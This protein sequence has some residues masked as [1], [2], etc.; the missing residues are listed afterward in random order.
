MLEGKFEKKF[1]RLDLLI[2]NAGINSKDDPNEL[3]DRKSRYLPADLDPEEIIRHI[4]I[5]SISILMVKHF[6]VLEK[7]RRPLVISIS[8]WLG[9][10]GI[11]EN[12]R[13]HY[14]YCF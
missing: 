3:L 6:R 4:R 5:N 1:S 9:G 13:A 7:L 10:I 12:N 14:S 11:K 2:N 8:S